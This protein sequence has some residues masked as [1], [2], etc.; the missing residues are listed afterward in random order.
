MNKTLFKSIIR[1]IKAEKIKFLSIMAL[2]FIATLAFAAVYH[3]VISL[4]DIPDNFFKETN[5]Q[6][7]TITST[8]GLDDEDEIIIGSNPYVEDFEMSNFIDLI[9]KNTQ[10]IVRLE[11]MTERITLSQLVK[12][13]LPENRYEIVLSENYSEE[14][15]IADEISF[16]DEKG[17]TEIDEIRNNTFEIVG[18]VKKAD[19]LAKNP[20]KISNIGSGRLTGFGL[21]KENV[22]KREYYTIARIKID[23][24]DKAFSDEYKTKINTAIES[25]EKDFKDRPLKRLEEVKTDINKEIADGKKEIADAIKELDEARD[26]LDD[27]EIKLREAKIDY[28]KARIDLLEGKKELEDGRKEYYDGEAEFEKE[29]AD[30]ERKLKE[31]EIELQD[32]KLA[33]KDGE[34]EILNARKELEDGKRDLA[35]AEDKLN[36]GIREYDKGY[37]E[38]L[39]GEREW[40]IAKKIY[41]DGLGQYE[42]G[43]REY[44]AGVKE[45]EEKKAM[46][47]KI[48]PMVGE[49]SQLKGELEADG[50]KAKELT[51]RLMDIE[52]LINSGTL[53]LEEMGKLQAEA[54]QIKSELENLQN[55]IKTNKN[56]LDGILAQLKNFGINP[57]QISGGDIDS[58]ISGINSE[59]K[60]GEE[61]LK[62]SKLELDAGKKELDEGKIELDLGEEKLIESKKELD[63]AWAEIEDGKREIEDGKADLAKGQADLDEGIKELND[64]KKKYQDGLI[65]Y[66]DGKI[67]LEDERAKGKREL[68]EA[69]KELE[70]GEKEYRDGLIKLRDGRREI[71]DAERDLKEGKEE[72]YDKSQE[73]MADIDKGKKDIADAEDLVAKLKTPEFLID[74]RNADR[75]YHTISDFPRGLKQLVYVFSTMAFAVASLVATTS[76]TRMIDENRIL[77]GTL[78]G[79][80][81]KNEDIALKYI[82]FGGISGVLGGILGALFGQ[83]YLG[84]LIYEIYMGEF[85]IG[86]IN[87]YLLMRLTIPAVIMAFITTV[88]V[89][90]LTVRSTLNESAASLLRP[91]AP[92]AGNRVFIEKIEPLWQRLSFMNKITL[93]NIFRYKVRMLMTILG[94]GVC[95]ALIILGFSMEF[96]V[97]QLTD[98]QFEEINQ[99]TDTLILEEDISDEN[100]NKLINKIEADKNIYDK[101]IFRSEDLKLQNTIV[102]TQDAQFIINLEN[103]FENMINFRNNGE[104]IS[105]EDGVLVSEKLAQL[106]DL[107]P[108][109][110][111]TIEFK[112]EDIELKLSNTFENYFGHYIYM[113]REYYERVFPEGLTPNGIYIKKLEDIDS[114]VFSKKLLEED[115]ILAV[116]SNDILLES[117]EEFINSLDLIVKIIIIIAMALAI[118]VLY[119]LT[120]INV[121]ERIRE[122]STMKVLGFYPREVSQYIS[123]EIVGLSI[124]G[125]FLGAII[126]INIVDFIL[127]DFAPADMM[128]SDPNFKVSIGISALL[129]LGFTFIVLLVLHF[130]LKK[131]DMLEAL[132]SVE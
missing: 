86:D 116:I 28:E 93:R 59:L 7:I 125:I 107:K 46:V 87:G 54:E 43:L 10:E 95:M 18:F 14:Y 32:G 44:E 126:G 6:D 120:S 23:S 90:Y 99:Y 39:K 25:L 80:G 124:I 89:S 106:M 91:K 83:L 56:K 123:K 67:K 115:S 97:S 11:T 84:P 112:G 118:V 78:K 79:L 102:G 12:G 74:S 27:G 81:Y 76:L 2:L 65:E 110:K 45:L 31:A 72:F 63:K 60:A 100:L 62:E 26:E 71:L 109:D 24:E 5:F 51:A 34:V 131:L 77:I 20:S 108:G 17:N 88:L 55:N 98:L 101:N 50:R 15:S 69:K 48:V 8:L 70:D 111:F 33:I 58:V 38:Y 21:V 104:S 42:A 103:D 85:I 121:S 132:S 119:N 47:D 37:D 52:A 35:E 130:R 36:E 94:V 1:D 13:K 127:A 64:A 4:R 29:I 113:N 92:K 117:S 73:A 114:E 3:G 68:A 49:I 75:E 57:D 41:E 122:L 82:I 19:Y 16:E 40:L 96:S 30:A 53:D 22:F 9:D 66:N 129:T 61:K 105:F 128:F